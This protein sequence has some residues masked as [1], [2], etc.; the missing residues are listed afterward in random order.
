ML[1]GLPGSGKSTWAKEQMV[2]GGA[3]RINR[4]EIRED[5][6]ITRG[7]WTPEKEKDVLTMR[8]GA[9]G[10]G[11]DL[12]F[13]KVIIDDTNLFSKH[14]RELREIARYYDAV[15]EIKEFDTPIEECIR[16]DALRTGPAC[17]GEK[18][19]R[20][21]AKDSG[22]DKPLLPVVAPTLYVPNPVLPRAIICDLDGTL[23]LFEKKGH[24]GPYDASKCDQD[25]CNLVVRRMLEVYYRFMGHCI[26]YVSGRFEKFRTPTN[27]FLRENHCPP[28][29]L[30]MRPDNDTRNDAIVKQEIFDR[31]IRHYYNVDFVLDDRDRVVKMWR[32]LGLTCLQVNDGNF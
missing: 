29:V 12:G 26:L 4:D 13:K 3:C 23:S 11:F 24:R 7:N 16:R 22:R 19:I 27:T 5:M 18:V 10:E 15:F 32:S 6:G 28:G 1:R 17:A 9:I 30:W 2:D 21:M 20:K 14:E 8:D 31:E 25:D